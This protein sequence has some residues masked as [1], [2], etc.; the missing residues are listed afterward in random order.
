METTLKPSVA[1]LAITP[2]PHA[3]T[4]PTSSWPSV[5]P[6]ASRRGPLCASLRTA[7]TAASVS[8]CPSP[9]RGGAGA[10]SDSAGTTAPRWT[11]WAS[12]REEAYL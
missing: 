8:G 2:S 7:A 10:A 12:Q 11:T 4:A 9:R 5:S 1:R 6:L 3:G